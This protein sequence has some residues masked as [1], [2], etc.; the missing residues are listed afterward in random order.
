MIVNG[1]FLAP[2]PT[3]LHRVARNLLDAA[4]ATGWSAPVWAPQGV[5][6]VRVD[7]WLPSPPGPGTHQA[8][9]QVV[10]PAAARGRRILSLTNTAPLA[11]RRSTVMVHDLAPLVGP[12]WFRPRMRWYARLVR[13]AARRA[14]HVLTVSQATAD[15]LRA[16]GV[17][18]PISVVPPSVAHLPGPSTAEEV[19]RVHLSHALAPSVPYLLFVG[20][21]DPR[22]DLVTA[23]AAHRLA[24]RVVDHRLVLVGLAHPTFAPVVAPADAT[25]RRLGFVPDEDLRALLTGAAALVYPTRYEGFGLPPLEAAACGTSALVSDLPVLRETAAGAA[26]FVPPGDVG[27]WAEAMVAALQGEVAAGTLPPRTWE[28]AGRDLVAVLA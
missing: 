24:Q 20:W 11:S 2:T 17:A 27:A 10:L 22:K 1:R 15:D 13:A 19:A 25:V 4:Q 9:E 18:A 23:L 6:D 3:G 7:R 12:T 21:A 28:D 26:T 14:E 8:F 5:D 16:A